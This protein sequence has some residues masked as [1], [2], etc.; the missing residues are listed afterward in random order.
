VPLAT[1]IETRQL[2]APVMME[3]VAPQLASAAKV[4]S[5][6]PA[7]VAANPLGALLALGASSSSQDNTPIATVVAPA[8]SCRHRR[9]RARFLLEPAHQHIAVAPPAATGAATYAAA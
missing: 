3:A 9:W 2:R 6:S 8:A 7:P 1:A 5:S 4:S